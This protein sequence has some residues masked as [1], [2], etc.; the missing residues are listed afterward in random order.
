MKK[1]TGK[2]SLSAEE[3]VRQAQAE[4]M[5]IAL[6]QSQALY[7]NIP[8]FEDA[9]L[10]KMYGKLMQ[11]SAS[12]F[13]EI[14]EKQVSQARRMGEY[15]PEPDAIMTACKQ[16]MEF[17]NDIMQQAMGVGF[18]PDYP[19]GLDVYADWEIIRKNDNSLT[20]EQ[21]RLLAYGAPL[22][23]YND[24]N[25]DSLE[26]TA[27][28]DT[29][30]EMLEEWW[31]VTDS[32]TFLES[33]AWLLDEG[34]HAGADSVLAEIRKRGLEAITEEE[35][36][37][38]SSKTGD[39]VTISEFVLGINGATEKELPET[40]LGWDLVRAVNLARWAFICGYIG[41]DEM[42]E[43][44]RGVAVIARKTFNS[45]EKYGQSFALGRGIWRG[46]TDDYE[47]ADEVVRALLSKEGSP[48]KTVGW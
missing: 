32:E 38:E 47:T 29:L 40:V 24:D 11:D 7:G 15:V 17:A 2:V 31:E 36:S 27:D 19:D 5:K 23:L 48:W 1:E 3:S 28:T 22:C 14:V 42:W 8:G 12:M 43:T 6:E 39:V 41:E 25:V 13:S 44:V 16:N 18:L 35:K 21:Y 33:I 46:N 4:A 20:A 26:S 9:D 45:W 37:D 30:K 10:M 34:Q